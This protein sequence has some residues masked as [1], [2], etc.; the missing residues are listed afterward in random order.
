M[1][2]IFL[3]EARDEM[4]DAARFYETSRTGLSCTCTEIHAIGSVG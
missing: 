2:A 3:D 4:M 1:T